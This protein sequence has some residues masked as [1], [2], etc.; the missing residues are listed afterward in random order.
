[1]SD[2]DFMREALDLARRAAEAGEVPVGAVLVRDGAIVGRGYNQPVSGKDPTAHA[3]VVALRDAAE[4]IG[5]YRLGECEMFVTLEPCA[6][7]AGAIMHARLSRVVYGAADPKSGACG[8]VVDLFAEG[9]L[10]HHATI[11]GGVM[12]E[13]AGA[14]LRD[15]FAVRRKVPRHA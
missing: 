11:V 8:S 7:C 10:N 14:M 5:N 4:R 6:M 15:F 1:M 12:A 3:E 9:R 13:E 2:E